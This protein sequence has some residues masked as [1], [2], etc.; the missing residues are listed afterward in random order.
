MDKKLPRIVIEIEPPGQI[1]EIYTDDENLNEICLVDWNADLETA[2]PAEIKTINGKK[3]VV[4]LWRP[5][6]SK[7]RVDKAFNA[8]KGGGPYLEIG[9]GV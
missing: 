9:S 7:E 5:H 6:Y 4:V 8:V 2:M 1:E 3:V